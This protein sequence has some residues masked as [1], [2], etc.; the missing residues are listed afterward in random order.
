MP[1][2]NAVRPENLDSIKAEL[3]WALS[4]T[5]GAPSYLV[6]EIVLNT[7][8]NAQREGRINQKERET[9][10]DYIKREYGYDF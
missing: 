4:D 3:D 10:C 1:A 7:L 9:A 6:V 8:D 5:Q 2:K